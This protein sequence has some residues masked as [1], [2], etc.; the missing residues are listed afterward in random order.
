MSKCIECSTPGVNLNVDF[1]HLMSQYIF[2]SY[3][4]SGTL[5]EEVI[6]KE[7][8]HVCRREYMEKLSILLSILL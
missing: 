4:K 6:V 2:I 7:D 8:V 3:N 5:G 1:G